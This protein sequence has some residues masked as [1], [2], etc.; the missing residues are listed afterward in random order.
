MGIIFELY[1]ECFEKTDAEQ[2]AAHFAGLKFD[3]LTGTVAAW[4]TDQDLHLR[5]TFGLTV[6]SHN[7]TASGIRNLQDALETTESGL[8]LYQHL[9]K[10]PNFE[11]AHVGIEAE[12]TSIADLAR[13]NVRGR[14]PSGGG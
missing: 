14:P 2:V 7:L 8:R 12:Q 1:V 11:F 4:E 3:L 10:G 13:L 9:Q 5:D 6:Y